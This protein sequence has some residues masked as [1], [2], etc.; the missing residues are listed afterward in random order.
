[1]R[2][3]LEELLKG[4]DSKEL[5]LSEILRKGAAV[6]LQELLEQE[7]TDFLGRGHYE[8]KKE[9]I[10]AIAM[11]MSLSTLKQPKEKSVYI[12]LR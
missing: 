1:M 8:R 11:A 6:I 10:Q 3:E 9:K 5:L 2:R 12:S 7:V 4:T